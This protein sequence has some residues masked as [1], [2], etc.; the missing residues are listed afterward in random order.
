[1]NMVVAAMRIVQTCATRY[2]LFKTLYGQE[3]LKNKGSY[4]EF[5][6]K[7]KLI[8]LSRY[9][10]MLVGIHSQEITNYRNIKQKILN[11]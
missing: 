10:K 11:F 1:M 9:I 3:G 8:C 4:L 6:I 7:K 2:S 5:F